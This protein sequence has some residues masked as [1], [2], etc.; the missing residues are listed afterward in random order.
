[1]AL[2][3]YK[4]ILQAKRRNYTRGPPRIATPQIQDSAN[5]A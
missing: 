4:H 2:Y 1:M 3:R 5:L